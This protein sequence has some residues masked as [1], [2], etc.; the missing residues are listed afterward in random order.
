MKKTRRNVAMIFVLILIAIIIVGIDLIISNSS[1]DSTSSETV[2][3][4]LIEV[5]ETTVLYKIPYLNDHTIIYNPKE[6][7]WHLYGIIRP[8]TRFIHLTA[9]S[10]T[11]QE[12]VKTNSFSDGGA[13]IWAPHIIYHDSIYH[14]FYTKIGI[15]RE[16]HHV[17]S[18]DL[19]HWS[20]SLEPV[21]ALCNE[22]NSNLKNKDPMV[23]RDDEKKQWVMYY[24]MMKDD[25]HWVVGYS[26]SAD[27]NNWSEPN[28]CFDENTESPGVESPFVAKH[29]S[30]YY[31]FLSARPWPIGGEDIFRSKSPYLWTP[32]NLVKRID[33]WHAA[34][35]V[36]DLDGKWYLT[37]SSGT[38][39]KDLKIAPLYWK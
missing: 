8:H 22:Y 30:Y 7:K 25:K 12:W 6:N 9:D 34:E 11:Q 32:D 15:P 39:E 36:R 5:G 35:V 33:P 29:G 4:E 13:E 2:N 27:L 23:F 18:G 26:T 14:M 31:L 3:S 24:S 10:L 28:I 20:K 21:L 37:L 16:I 19:Y 38:Q 1:E 17:T